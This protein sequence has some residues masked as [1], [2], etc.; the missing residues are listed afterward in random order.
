MGAMRSAR[1]HCVQKKGGLAAAFF[2][3]A[4]EEARW[5]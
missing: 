3:G 4:L 2:P 1:L 5:R